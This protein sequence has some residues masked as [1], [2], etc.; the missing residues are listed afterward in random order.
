MSKYFVLCK[1]LQ[2]IF[3][4]MVPVGIVTVWFDFLLLPMPWWLSWLI[5][6]VIL[7]AGIYIFILSKMNL[8]GQ[9]RNLL[10]KLM[11]HRN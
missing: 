2:I 10:Q 11:A 3:I 8:I 9:D 7:A 4:I 5:C 6:S 1:I